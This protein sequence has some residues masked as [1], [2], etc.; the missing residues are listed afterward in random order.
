[1][2]TSLEQEAS[3]IATWDTSPRVAV[4]TLGTSVQGRPI[5]LL[6]IGNPAPSSTARAT[7]L[8]TGCVHGNEPAGR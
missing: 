6:R 5:R 4:E 3:L 2:W 1:M 8:L 7:L